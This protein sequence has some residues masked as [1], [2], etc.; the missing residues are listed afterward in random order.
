MTL[1]TA[2]ENGLSV[3]GVGLT[4]VFAVL[5]ILM[6]VL[7]LMKVVFYKDPNKKQNVV[8]TEQ[9]ATSVVQAPKAPK[10]MDDTELIAVLTAA[11]AASLNTSTY[12]LKIKSYRRI[13]N[14]APAWNR[15]GVTET[16]NGRF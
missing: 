2:L 3:T 7:M 11:V 6:L 16:I 9:T 15:A 5:V 8:K 4:I 13:G 1:Q 14:N 12:N 10:V